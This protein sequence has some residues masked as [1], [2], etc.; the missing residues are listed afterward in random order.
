MC[1]IVTVV[2]VNERWTIEIIKKNG[3]RRM[4]DMHYFDQSTAAKI[5]QAYAKEKNIIYIPFDGKIITVINLGMVFVPVRVSANNKIESLDNGYEK[6]SK[7]IEAAQKIASELKIS[8]H[9]LSETAP[10]KISAKKTFLSRFFQRHQT[11]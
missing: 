3:K 8:F 10:K 6:Y 5:A 1:S 4:E 9:D 2:S 7:A 11:L